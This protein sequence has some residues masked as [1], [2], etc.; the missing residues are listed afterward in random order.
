[1]TAPTDLQPDPHD[2]AGNGHFEGPTKL[3]RTLV[4]VGLGLLWGSLFLLIQN[5]QDS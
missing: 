2:H 5:K 1:M 4:G 3:S